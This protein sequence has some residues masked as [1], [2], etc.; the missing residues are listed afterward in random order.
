MVF[1]GSR[2]IFSLVAPGHALQTNVAFGKYSGLLSALPCSAAAH[3]RLRTKLSDPASSGQG[4]LDLERCAVRGSDPRWNF[5]RSPGQ[6][7]VAFSG[8]TH[9]FATLHCV[10]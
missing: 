10:E 7:G 1:K 9:M 6:R 8:P 2:C 5:H 3:S 4:R